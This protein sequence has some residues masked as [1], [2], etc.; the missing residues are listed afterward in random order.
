MSRYP[1]TKIAIELEFLH[2]GWFR[3]WHWYKYWFRFE[4]VCYY[5]TKM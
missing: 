4:V 3:N 1:H 5:E 2:V